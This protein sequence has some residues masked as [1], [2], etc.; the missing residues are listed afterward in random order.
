[1]IQELRIYEIFEHNK[2]AFHTRFRDQAVPI[3]R[4][5]GFHIVTM[6]E[7]QGEKGPEF[8][9]I[10]NWPDEGTRVAAWETF[11]AD[12]EWMEIKR[13]TAAKHGDL[14]GGIQNRVLTRTDYSPAFPAAI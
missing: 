6:W 10:L 11:R 9:Y 7:C 3:F 1:M 5:H 4:R 13:R 2:A 8:V 14:V 12:E